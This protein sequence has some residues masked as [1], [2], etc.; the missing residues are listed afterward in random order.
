MPTSP[1]WSSNR[2]ERRAVIDLGT[3]TFHLLVAEVGNGRIEEVYRERIFVKL[4]SDGIGRIGPAPF[5][6]GIA[7]LIH[8]RKK[9]DALK[10]L[11]VRAIGTAALRTAVNGR[12]F[13]VAA[14]HAGAKVELISGDEEAR[15][16]TRGVLAALPPTDERILIM[17]IGG[18][19]TEYIVV[20]DGNVL[21]QRSFPVG[22]SVLKNDF[23]HRDPIGDDEAAA[24]KIHLEA[25]TK[26]L[27]AA[28]HNYPTRRLVGA[29]GTFDVL[30]TLLR[31]DNA[32]YRPTAHELSLAGWP[33]LRDR[34]VQAT[35]AERGRF[36]GLPPQRVDM[37]VVAMLL[38]DFTFELADVD[39]VTVSRYALKEGVL[40]DAY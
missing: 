21:F 38:L 35:T 31:D 18:G 5:Q 15:L 4:A 22:V 26:P 23:H 29:A 6:R 8:F 9:L 24:V 3:N 2:A 25:V 37:I 40:L 32:P 19:S 20:E 13:L 39:R 14:G 30:A 12:E 7:A 27:A 17:D 36:P 16:I 34:I 28:L 1:R 11:S 10:C 33:A